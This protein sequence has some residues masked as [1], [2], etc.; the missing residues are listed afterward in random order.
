M[1]LARLLQPSMVILEDVDLISILTTN[2]PE[3]LETALASRPG[4]VDQAIEFPVPD[5]NGRKKL[6]SLYSKGISLNEAWIT[7]IIGRTKGVS[8]SFIKEL[9]RRIV[10]YHIERKGDGTINQEDIES[11]LDE[12][13]SRGS[14]LNQKLLGAPDPKTGSSD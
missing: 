12:M 4:M 13:L 2:R 14:V 11:A 8:A 6:V 7:E 9:M 10:Q 5:R 1:T 3:S